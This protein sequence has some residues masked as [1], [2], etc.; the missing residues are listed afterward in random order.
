MLE[1]IN[2]NWRDDLHRYIL[3]RLPNPQIDNRRPCLAEDWFVEDARP[4]APNWIADTDLRR[5]WR[6]AREKRVTGRLGGCAWLLLHQMIDLLD[7]FFDK[8]EE[9]RAEQLAARRREGSE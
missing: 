7:A 4:L 9:I 5:I 3:D 8:W 1:I 6:A 2:P